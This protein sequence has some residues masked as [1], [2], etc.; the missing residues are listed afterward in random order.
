MKANVFGSYARG[1]GGSPPESNL[2]L[3]VELESSRDLFDLGGLQYKLK[4]LLGCN[5]DVTM[6]LH[7]RLEPYIRPELVEI[8]IGLVIDA[9]ETVINRLSGNKEE[10]LKD[11]VLQD[12]T[13]MQ[14]QES[15]EHLVRICDNFTDYYESHHTEAWHQLIGLHNIIAHGSMQINIDKVW[16]TVTKNVPELLDNLKA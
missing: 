4:R 10:F 3:L 9:L 15:G 1:R 11:E 12:A 8:H 13:L 16:E 14:L 6:K 2:G 5:V 7:P